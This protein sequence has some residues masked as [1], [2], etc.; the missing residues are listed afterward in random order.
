[1][2]STTY[3]RSNMSPNVENC[4]DSSEPFKGV[5]KAPAIHLIVVPDEDVEVHVF[6]RGERFVGCLR[7]LRRNRVGMVEVTA[8]ENSFDAF[9][10]AVLS[11]RFDDFFLLLKAG[12][13]S[14]DQ[15]RSIHPL[16][17]VKV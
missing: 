12:V 2:K 3:R 9:F 7:N 17:Q 15:G 6:K 4:G 11:N 10:F 1:M 8:E 16:M 14:M 13:P 5:Y